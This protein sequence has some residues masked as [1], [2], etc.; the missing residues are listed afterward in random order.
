[1]YIINVDKKWTSQMLIPQYPVLVLKLFPIYTVSL[2]TVFSIPQNQCYSG[3]PSTTYMWPSTIANVNS[4]IP[5]SSTKIVPDL[6]G[7][8]FNMVFSIPQNQCY[9]R[10]QST[11]YM[12]PS[13][14]LCY[15]PYCKLS[16][17]YYI[18]EHK[19]S[20]L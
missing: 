20:V 16:D 10:T 1:M 2:N 6:H 17:T 19:E 4:P 5:H 13:T 14:F 3:N 9:S 11:T 7:F 8:T 12:W 18:L 15:P